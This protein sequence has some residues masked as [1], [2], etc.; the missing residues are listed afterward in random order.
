[1]SIQS[2][3][4]KNE[5]SRHNELKACLLDQIGRSDCN[6]R[7]PSETALAK[8]FNVCRATMNKV[9]VELER[10]GYV[11]RRPGKGTFVSPRDKTVESSTARNGSRTVMIAYP[12][13]FAYP[14]WQAVHFAE[15]LALKQN[16][17]LI[18]F[19]MKNSLKMVLI[20]TILT[21]IKSLMNLAQLIWSKFTQAIKKMLSQMLLVLILT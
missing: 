12:D 2:S 13:F 16:L 4:F 15:M 1:M 19:K 6:M 8:Q 20:D 17:R 3:V 11:V 10:E 5:N 14:L 18:N 9:M 21:S 7:L